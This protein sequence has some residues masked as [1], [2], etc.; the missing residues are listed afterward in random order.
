[1]V[2]RNRDVRK[3]GKWNVVDLLLLAGGMALIA[4]VV[5]ALGFFHDDT[6]QSVTL[7]YTVCIGNVDDT[8]RDK[9]QVGDTVL[10]ATTKRFLGRVAAVDNTRSHTVFRYDEETGGQ[11]VAVPDS[12]DIVITV[13]SEGLFEDKVGYTVEQKRLAVGAE[14]TLLF[15]NYAGSGYCTSIR[16]VN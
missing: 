4:G 1:M 12:Y 5:F 7:S 3:R 10:D 15:P 11:M 2:E 8:Y 13:L 14:Y 16:E 6:G 9:I